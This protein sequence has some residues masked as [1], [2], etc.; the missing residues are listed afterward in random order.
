MLNPLQWAIK[1]G[2]G[3]ICVDCTF[4]QSSASPN[5]HIPAPGLSSG[6]DCPP[7]YYGTAFQRYLRYIY[8]LRLTRPSEP[9]FQHCNDIQAAFRRL[10]YHP[11]LAPAH[12]YVFTDFLIVPCAGI[13]GGRSVPSLSC[14]LAEMR[15]YHAATRSFSDVSDLEPVVS[16]LQLTRLPPDVPFRT[17][18]PDSHYSPFPSEL[19]VPVN[20]PCYVDDTAVA[21]FGD[22]IRQQINNSVVA[23][24]NL[25]GTPAL[26]PL[27]VEPFAPDKWAPLVQETVLF[28]GLLVCSR[29]L[30][31]HWPLSKRQELHEQLS[32]ILQRPSPFMKAKEMASVLGKLRSVQE[33]AAFGTF[34]S[35]SLQHQL[36]RLQRYSRARHEDPWRKNCIFLNSTVQHDLRWL[37]PK[38]VDPASDDLWSTPLGLLIPRDSTI[39]CLADASYD[40]IGGWSPTLRFMWHIYTLL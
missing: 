15:S 18:S 22:S 27:I 10:L 25:I 4:D 23:A 13:F 17:A 37:L 8:E 40:G 20:Q 26:H 3:R 30:T 29:T 34:Y 1:H 35:T 14:A 31:V 21:A 12:A 19:P 6:D 32:T 24:N 5:S 36:T 33:I 2:K 16:A 28:L 38:L 11:D 39:R 9:I 7:I